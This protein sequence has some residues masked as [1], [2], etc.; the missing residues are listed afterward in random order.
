MSVRLVRPKTA[1]LDELLSHEFYKRL[2][3]SIENV[4]PEM[5]NVK[6]PKKLINAKFS[7]EIVEIYEIMFLGSFNKLDMA[8]LEHSDYL[9]H[10]LPCLSMDSF[11]L[12]ANLDKKSQENFK[13]IRFCTV[14]TCVWSFVELHSSGRSEYVDVL[15][16]LSSS[17]F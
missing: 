5:K 15:S 6:D 16:N 1:T 4:L 13:K 17:K 8:S 12:I 10:L 2:V 3:T 9:S 7:K 11:P 14:M